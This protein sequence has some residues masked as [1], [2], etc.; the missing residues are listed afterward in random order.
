MS[1]S[2]RKT[3]SPPRVRGKVFIIWLV[4]FEMRIT[5][6][7]AGKSKLTF[8]AGQLIPGSPPRVRGKAAVTPA[9]IVGAGIT[10]ASAG[11]RTGTSRGRLFIEDHPRECGEKFISTKDILINQG[12]PP[13]VRGK[14]FYVVVT[15]DFKRITPA[16]AGKSLRH[17]Q[18]GHAVQDHPRE[19]GEKC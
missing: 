16:S 4:G 19:C 9:D 13:R 8:D 5:P 12:S 6:A 14:G 7:S 11:K 15:R 18:K 2:P 10:P 17:E 3:G 1:K